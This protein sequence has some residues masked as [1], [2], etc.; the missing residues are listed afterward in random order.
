[1]PQS[2]NSSVAKVR[3]GG[4]EYPAVTE[5]TCYTCA[6]PFRAQIEEQAVAGRTWARIVESLPSD[7]GLTPRNLA[8]HWKNGHLPVVEAT[9]QALVERQAEDRGGVVES[10]VAGVLE[11]LDFARVIVGRVRQRVASGELE[12]DIGDALR[13]AD[14]LARYDTEPDTNEDDY[15]QAFIAYN[16]EAAEVMTAEQFAKFGERLGQN[17][18]LHALAQEWDQRL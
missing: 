8:D 6:S 5:R 4:H 17:Q 14:L 16:D 12:P 11:H 7:A 18:I 10:A 13:A 15:L 3:V 1:M 9:V 2:A